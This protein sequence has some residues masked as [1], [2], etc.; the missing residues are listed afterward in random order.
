VIFGKTASPEFGLT[1]STESVLFG[2]TRNPWKPTHM[3]GGSSGGAAAAVAAGIVPAAHASDGGGSIRIPASCCGLFGLKPTRAR[4]P[5]GPDAGEG[6]SGMSA[7]H[8]VSRSVRDS[9]ALLDA[10]HGPA[11]GDPYFAPAPERAFLDEVG[12]DPGRLRIAVQTEAFNGCPTH[13]DCVAAVRDAAELLAS[14]GHHVEEAVFTPDREALGRATQVIIAANV[15]AT[16]LDR[17]AAL[18]RELRD[19]DIE[20]VTRGMALLVKDLE[21]AEYPRAVRTIHTAGRQVAAFFEG[22]DALLTPTLACPPMELGRLALTNSDLPAF[23][24]AITQTVGFTQLFNATGNPAAS[25]PLSWNGDGLPIGVQ[26]AGRFGDEATLLR[27]SA[28]LEQARP[29]FG[30]RPGLAAD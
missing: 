18:G 20:P 27:L 19:D 10:T 25:L 13:A 3:A 9:A 5:A 21:A 29:W 26:L 16:A 2:Q 17:A 14:L 24:G 12:A 23:L 4:I 22:Y 15:R 11:A 30:R 28:Q 8:V 6:W 1:T 7:N